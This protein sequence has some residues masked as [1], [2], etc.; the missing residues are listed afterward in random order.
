MSDAIKLEF[1]NINKSFPGV[2]ALDNINMKV[3]K[4]TIHVICG[5]NGAGK[6]TLMKILDGIYPPDS[7]EIY[8]D[9]QKVQIKSPIDAQAY[10]IGMVFQELS[11]V[12]DMTIEENI[13]CGRWP[14]KN[15]HIDWGT[16]HEKAI[17]FMAKEK[18]HYNPKMLMRSLSTSAIQ[19]I[20]I[21][22]VISFN[23]S[24]LVMDEPTSSISLQETDYLLE[25]L[26]ELRNRGVSIIYISHKM[27]EVFRI[28]DDITV[29]RDGAVVDTEPASELNVDK[30]ISMMVGRKLGGQYPKEEIPIGDIALEVKNFT[31]PGVFENISFNVHHGEIVG[32]AGLVGAGRTETMR[33]VFGI[34]PHTKGEVLV[35]NRQV[36]IR[37][38]KDA[39]DAGLVYVSED[40]RRMEIIPCRNIQENTS[41]ASLSRFFKKGRHFPKEEAAETARACDQMNVKASSYTDSVMS[42]SGGNQQKVVLAKW[43]LCNP[44][45]L[46][47]DEPTRGIDV[48]AK[49]EIYL[50]LSKF[51]KDGKAVVMVSSEMP[52][53][54]GMCDRIYVMCEGKITGCLERKE[55]S[56]IAIM[57][58]A[59][60][61][62]SEAVSA[63]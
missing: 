48:G 5:E 63:S 38:P 4:G 50:Q 22:K 12:P 46:L 47:M 21:L 54:L 55:F 14:T 42:L 16:L 26:L 62:H 6:S 44:D 10:G 18:I 23:A 9:G 8:I 7:G 30:V 61:N 40:R 53:L 33:A 51:A 60:A 37:Q 25:K 39:I 35:N 58:L 49:R 36:N 34:D 45:I 41:V 56:Q 27:D 59:I 29:L 3:R 17:E 31:Q 2:K 13:F 1:K 43:F 19:M 20:E 28:A 52:E 24:I 57:K 32:F 15:G 11:F